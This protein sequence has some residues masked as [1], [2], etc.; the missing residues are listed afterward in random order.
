M[1]E[2]TAYPV[3]ARVLSRKARQD[4]TGV[5]YGVVLPRDLDKTL[6]WKKEDTIGLKLEEQTAIQVGAGGIQEDPA[7]PVP[8]IRAQPGLETRYQNEIREWTDDKPKPVIRIPIAWT[9]SAED[10]TPMFPVEKGESLTVEIN[11]DENELRIYRKEDFQYRATMIELIEGSLSIER[12][13]EMYQPWTPAYEDLSGDHPGQKVRIIPF[14]GTHDVFIEANEDTDTEE[15]LNERDLT[16]VVTDRGAPPREEMKEI[17]LKGG[18]TIE[19]LWDSSATRTVNYFRSETIH[20]DDLKPTAEDLDNLEGR[21][22]VLEYDDSFLLDPSVGNLILPENGAFEI[23]VQT[24]SFPIHEGETWLV[25]TA[26][27]DEYLDLIGRRVR[28]NWFGKYHFAPGEQEVIDLF[29]SMMPKKD[30]SPD[31]PGLVPVEE[32]PVTWAWSS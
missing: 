14:D 9:D 23:R 28:E 16:S 27:R 30:V 21:I 4:S 11:P 22:D 10:R 1:S 20:L 19:V 13:V 5:Y 29:I 15:P 7:G 24:A 3:V 6:G 25:H 32:V 8:Y 31:E 17:G 18:F 2:H 12:P 26:E